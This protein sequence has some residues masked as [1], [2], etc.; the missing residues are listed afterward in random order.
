M[1]ANQF[2]TEHIEN[3]MIILTS[4]HL[5]FK[6]SFERKFIQRFIHMTNM[7]KN[8]KNNGQSSRKSNKW[9][10]TI[11]YQNISKIK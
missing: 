11:S 9:D 6:D 7:F 8:K 4:E 1:E 10:Q 2:S 3:E 5:S